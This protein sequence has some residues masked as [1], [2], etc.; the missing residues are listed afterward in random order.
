MR[1]DNYA[2]VVLASC[3]VTDG[4][5]G[6]GLDDSAACDNSLRSQPFQLHFEA[7]LRSLGFG[8]LGG[9][10]DIH[11]H[12]ALFLFVRTYR[13]RQS[14][15]P[16]GVIDYHQVAHSEPLSVAPLGVPGPLRTVTDALARRCGQTT[17]SKG[18]FGGL[19][20][21]A[22]GAGPGPP[23]DRAEMGPSLGEGSDGGATALN[24]A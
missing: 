6:I 14:R 7:P 18:S 21:E 12:V 1:R 17:W 22:A 11:L 8:L 24:Q 2:L 15:S 4:V 19:L 3:G 10:D 13:P 23:E 16:Q 20:E 5:I 9:D